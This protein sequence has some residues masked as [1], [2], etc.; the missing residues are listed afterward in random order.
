MGSEV[1]GGGELV[2]VHGYNFFLS[3]VGE[4]V[5]L[6]NQCFLICVVLV[7]FLVLYILFL[8]MMA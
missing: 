2:K 7:S 3:S 5:C 6:I 8:R 4:G 1:N